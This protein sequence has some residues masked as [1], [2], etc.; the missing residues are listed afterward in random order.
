[1]KTKPITHAAKVMSF[2]IVHVLFPK[3][4]SIVI[5]R[6]P[7][8]LSRDGIG[9]CERRLAGPAAD[10]PIRLR[11]TPVC[12]GAGPVLHDH[13]SSDS[14][15]C[16]KE[17]G[18]ARPASCARGTR[19]TG[20]GGAYGLVDLHCSPNAHT[21]PIVLL[22]RRCSSKRAV[23]D[24]SS[25]APNRAQ[26]AWKT[27]LRRCLSGIRRVAARRDLAVRLARIND[28]KAISGSGG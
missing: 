4:S 21:R 7:G 18:L 10:Q 27:L 11:A 8:D 9:I 26:R 20:N 3:S 19:H 15:R 16:R 22:G 1:M 17:R 2:N 5:R 12:N 24:Q 23:G 13:S 28:C 6:S 14:A 25:P